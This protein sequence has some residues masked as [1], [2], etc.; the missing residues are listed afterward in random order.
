MLHQVAFLFLDWLLGEVDGERLIG[1][2]EATDRP[3][4]GM[5]PDDL[6]TEVRRRSEQTDE[7]SWVLGQR[8]DGALVVANAAVK[9]ID[10]PFHANR[11]TITVDRGMEHMAGTDIKAD[12]EAAEDRL[13]EALAPAGVVELGRVTESRRRRSFLMCRDGAAAR[14][15]A[16]AWADAEHRWKA[17]VDVR[18]DA[19]WT[20]RGELGI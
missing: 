9:P 8:S 3:I 19:G 16:G 4:E 6:R 18:D 5:T 12:I 20:V 15:I 13:V 2:I 11:L 14:S 7:P 17:T 1:E 10:H